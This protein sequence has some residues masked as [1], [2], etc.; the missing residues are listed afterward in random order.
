M[1]REL[2]HNVSQA[3]HRVPTGTGL[4]LTSEKS[5]VPPNKGRR[6]SPA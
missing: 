5:S 2:S 1:R 3:D 4:T 6:F